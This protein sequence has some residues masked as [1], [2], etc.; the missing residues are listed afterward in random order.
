MLVSAFI[1]YADGV[2]PVISYN[3]GSKNQKQLKRVIK[4]S[5]IFILVLSVCMVVLCIVCAEPLISIYTSKTKEPELFGMVLDGMRIYPISFLFSGISI[6]ATRM[7]SALANGKLST[8]ISFVRNFLFITIGFLT[9]PQLFGLTGVW[10]VQPVA[11]FFS[12]LVALACMYSQRNVYGYG[13]VKN[14][15]EY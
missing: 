5:A 15:Y 11:E 6:F 13:T 1:G 10:L 4:D 8:T 3:Y 12:L 7:F 2:S 9:L 14:A